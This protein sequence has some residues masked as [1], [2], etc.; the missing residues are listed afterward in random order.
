MDERADHRPTPKP[1]RVLLVEDSEMDAELVLLAL[2]SGGYAVQHRRVDTR[3]DMS[4]ALEAAVWD[5]VIAD[6]SLPRFSSLEA[7]DL[8]RQR[9]L[10]LPF[11]IVSGTI[12]EETAVTAMKAGAQ[13]YLSKDNLTRLPAAIERELGDAEGRRERRRAELL[14]RRSEAY[15]RALLDSVPDGILVIDEHGRIEACNPAAERTFGFAP[16]EPI[17]RPFLDLLAPALRGAEGDPL[18]IGAREV[19]GLRRNGTSFPMDLTVS[20]MQ[21]DDGRRRIAI[22]RD[23]T[24][25]KRLEEQLLHAQKT[26]SLGRLAGGIAHDF[27]NLLAVMLTCAD[28]ALA[29]S[30]PGSRARADIEEIRLAAQRA[31][32]LTGQ[33]LMFSRRQVLK[34]RQLDLNGIIAEMSGMLRRL[35]GE[36][37]ELALLPA[38]G[39]R[40]VR[41]DRGQM[42]QVLMNLVLNA[43]DAMPGGGRLVIET[44]NVTVD[45]G[46]AAAH[47]DVRPGPFVLLAVSDTGVGMS[48]DTKEHLFEPFFTSKGPGKGTG[49]GLATAQSVVQQSGGFIWVHSEPE[50][51]TTFKI[52]LPAAPDLAIAEEAA[53]AAEIPSGSETVL[54]VEDERALREVAVRSLQRCG[55][56]VLQAADGFEAL[57]VAER[58]HGAIHLLLTDVVMPGMSG[59][60]LAERLQGARPGLKVVFTSGYTDNVFQGKGIDPGMGFLQKPFTIASLARALRTALGGP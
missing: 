41:L 48:D 60:R 30:P 33:L 3:G 32:G 35:I 44:A 58:H 49:L 2:R 59:R 55:Y 37:I 4:A 46:Y 43:R 54:V 50:S 26:E 36:D 9:G 6:H 39:L 24:Q 16:G 42:E 8:V 57:R 12:G 38:P 45:E 34:P 22:A 21:L 20:A 13:D 51:G 1:L 7:L 31:A 19:A 52:H 17:G 53:R 18:E 25:R 56:A 5:V 40:A 28:L 23:I 15:L 11:L 29:H 27:N 10:D 47:K 14:R